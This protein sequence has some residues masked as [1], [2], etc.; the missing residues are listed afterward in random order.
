MDMGRID[1]GGL[2]LAYAE[3]GEGGR[4]FILAHGF[5]GAKEDFTDYLDRLAEL[6]WHAVAPDNR[7]HGE[8][9]K[10]LGE[11]AYALSLFAAD[12]LAFADA[13]GFDTFVLLGHSMGGMFSQLLALKDP[14]RV[15]ALILMDTHHGALK[16]VDPELLE[17]GVAT[18]LKEGMAIVA[19]VVRDMGGENDPLATPAFLE[20]IRAHPERAIQSDRNLRVCSPFMYAACLRQIP[21]QEDR[22]E[23]LAQLTMPTLVIVGDQDKPFLKAS[24]RMADTIPNARLAVIANAG[25]SPQL[26]APDAWWNALSGFVAELG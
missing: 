17:L 25:H 3:A 9:D 7:G 18:A 21:T 20:Y 16:T 26:E 11:D 22:L 14:S 24:Q 6:G 10:P 12:T 8:S 23:R 5:T 1:I 15:E 2:E 4:P 13:L 19:D